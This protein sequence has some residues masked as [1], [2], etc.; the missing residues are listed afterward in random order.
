MWSS[1]SKQTI[2]VIGGLLLFVLVAQAQ[3][4]QFAGIGDLKLQNG[5][6]I[7]NC[8][9]GY[10]IFGRLNRDKSNVVVFTTWAGGGQAPL[11]DLFFVMAPMRS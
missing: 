4:Q 11:P 2:C 7:R 8:R 3:E 1:K 9:V 5:G 6:V 10:R